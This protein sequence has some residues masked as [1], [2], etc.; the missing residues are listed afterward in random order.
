MQCEILLMNTSSRSNSGLSRKKMEPI[1][2]KSLC[3]QME[4]RGF[5]PWWFFLT[6]RRLIWG[7][8]HSLQD[9]KQH[10]ALNTFGGGKE[11]GFIANKI[12]LASQFWGTLSFNGFQITPQM[13]L[14]KFICRE[15]SMNK[16]RQDQS[17]FE[18]YC[19]CH[20]WSIGGKKGH[21]LSIWH[22]KASLERL[23]ILPKFS[24][25]PT[26]LGFHS[27]V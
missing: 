17:S 15:I 20:H 13:S 24:K 18:T 9:I 16:E 8:M 21:H 4:L 25:M 26:Y 6:Q 19:M 2:L 10:L 27:S 12:F 14:W 3:L 22:W 7:K 23:Q 1:S 11:W 5:G